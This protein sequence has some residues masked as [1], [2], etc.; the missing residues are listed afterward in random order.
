[1]R[2]DLVIR[3][4]DPEYHGGTF[5]EQ[6]AVL[7]P[8][9]ID[10]DR[11][12]VTLI[13]SFV[14][15]CQPGAAS[16]DPEQPGLDSFEAWQEMDRYIED[17][18]ARGF[19]HTHPRCCSQWSGD[20]H[21]VQNGLAKANGGLL[22]WHGVQ[23]VFSERYEPVSRFV[24]V[25]MAHGEVFRYNYPLIADNIEQPVIR[26]ELPPLI[27]WENGAFVVG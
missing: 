10:E 13:R 26:L 8:L 5:R 21:C 11:G 27:K 15:V 1:M 7:Y 6:I 16:L 18:G 14:H 4:H 12:E 23:P 3:R 19:F 17:Q 2:D 25:W 20:D 22:L 24:C 9:D